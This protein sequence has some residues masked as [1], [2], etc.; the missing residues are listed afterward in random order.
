VTSDDVRALLDRY[1]AA[2]RAHDMA[3]L[4][5][6]GQ[7]TSSAQGEALRSYFDTVGPLEVEVTVLGIDR[8]GSEAVVRFI[9]RDRFTDPSGATRTQESPPITKRV[10]R[11]SQGLRFAAAP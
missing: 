2:W 5:A 3:T 7:V 9:R 6:I 10:I 11:T 4:E 1:A 8:I